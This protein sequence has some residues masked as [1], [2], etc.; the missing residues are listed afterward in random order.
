MQDYSKVKK[1]DDFQNE[2]LNSGGVYGFVFDKDRPFKQCHA[3]TVVESADGTIVVAWFGGDHEKAPNVGIWSSFYKNGEWSFPKEIAKVNGTAH[4][5]PVLFKDENSLIHLFFKI[6]PE[7]PTW[8]TY[9]MQ[10]ENGIDWNTS[11]EL[12]KEDVGGRGPVKNQPIVLSDGTWIAP[13]STELT[14]W[15]SFVDI[16]SDQGK[17]WSKSKVFSGKLIENEKIKKSQKAGFIKNLSEEDVR[18][19][20]D[21]KDFEKTLDVL[22]IKQAVW[23]LIDSDDWKLLSKPAKNIVHNI[24]DNDL[25][26]MLTIDKIVEN[27]KENQIGNV[28]SDLVLKEKLS[29]GLFRVLKDSLKNGPIQPTLWESEPGSVHALLRTAAG[30]LWRV[31]SIDFGKTWGDVYETALPNNN[32]GADVVKLKNGRLL[33]VMNPVPKNWGPRTPLTLMISD[34]NGENWTAMAHLEDEGAFLG[35]Q[36]FSYPTIDLANDGGVVISY[37][38]KRDDVICW[39]IPKEIVNQDI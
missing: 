29:D 21:N 2:I 39:K 22:D 30:Y 32:S 15:K 31:D 8:K 35:S 1:A 13:A 5:N 34:D 7:I 12:V 10:S 25:N 14:G 23:S 26:D 33:L 16:S 28:L 37:T 20:V 36:E 24:D 6:G 18:D 19:L 38:W 27:L 11:K 17:T 9:V 3:S 4:W